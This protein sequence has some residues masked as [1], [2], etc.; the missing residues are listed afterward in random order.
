MDERPRVTSPCYDSDRQ[1]VEDSKTTITIANCLFWE[2]ETAW[3]SSNRLV[4]I[5]PADLTVTNTQ[6]LDNYALVT[7][8]LNFC[9]YGNT[10]DD[11]TGVIGETNLIFENTEVAN[12]RGLDS[13]ERSDKYEMSP[14]CVA[15]YNGHWPT[16]PGTERPDVATHMV[17]NHLSC[18]DYFDWRT[19]CLMT[20]NFGD[21]SAGCTDVAVADSVMRDT[22]GMQKGEPGGSAVFFVWQDNTTIVRTSFENGGMIDADETNV[23]EGGMISLLA[24]TL[25][26][27]EN[28]SITNSKAAFGAAVMFVGPGNFEIVNS[29]FQG[30]VALEQGG[31]VFHKGPGPLDIS[32]SIFRMNQVAREIAIPV[33]IVVH[34][35]TGAT[36]NGTEILPVWKLDGDNPDPT[37]G[38]CG[39]EIVYG[40]EEY[41]VQSTYAKVITT[42]SGSHRLWHGMILN[43]ASAYESWTG[44]GWIDVMGILTRQ[45]VAVC[46]NRVKASCACTDD[47]TGHCTGN[48]LEPRTDGTCYQG[49]NVGYE[50]DM[51]YCPTGQTFWSYTDI[52]VPQGS[53]GAIATTGSAHVTVT[54]SEFSANAAGYGDALSVSGSESFQVKNT[55]FQ[56][57]N[58]D[59]ISTEG[60]AAYDCDR[61]PCEPG[62][63]CSVSQLS[64]SCEACPPGETGSNGVT[65]TPCGLGTEPNA[66]KT[67]CVQCADGRYSSSGICTPCAPGTVSSADRMTCTNC[68]AG[69]AAGLTTACATCAPNMISAGAQLF[70]EECPAGKTTSDFIGCVDC[71]D[72]FVRH[73]GENDC[74]PCSDG[75]EPNEARETCIPCSQ[76]GQF[77]NGRG[78]MACGA[79]TQPFANRTGCVPCPLG[80]AGITGICTPCAAG[81]SASVGSPSCQPCP[82]GTVSGAGQGCVMCE[83]GFQ[84]SESQDSCVSCVVIK[85]TYSSDGVECRDCPARQQPSTDLTS[86]NCMPNTYN[87]PSFGRV[88]CHGASG[89]ALETGMNDE[90]S[91]CPDCLD[92]SV[93]G[94]TRLKPG[95]AFYGLGEAFRCPGKAAVAESACVGP[96]L[97]NLSISEPTWAASESGMFKDEAMNEQCSGAYSGPVCGNCAADFHHLKVGKACSTCNQG[98][99]DI[100]ML[101]GFLFASVVAGGIVITGAYGILVDHGVITDL[102][103]LLGFYQLLGQM[104]NVLSISF[105][106]PVPEMLEMLGFL[107]LDLRK[108]IKMDCWD[109]GAC[110]SSA[111][112]PS[113]RPVF[114]SFSCS[115]LRLICSGVTCSGGFYGKLTTNVFAMPALCVG[116]CILYYLNQRRTIA[117]V[118]AAGGADESAY[119][120][121]TVGFQQ[122][123]F[124]SIF[125]LCAYRAV[126]QQMTLPNVVLDWCVDTCALCLRVAQTR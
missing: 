117:A 41:D 122:N 85:N 119:R 39:D 123:M 45:G 120:T 48:A 30:N 77:S 1:S 110:C 59:T 112:A 68:P 51:V 82:P 63:R 9:W 79:G 15:I 22:Y 72:G 65:C 95:W 108:F 58:S 53:G 4:D 23:G 98:T 73:T 40:G 94:A 24:T 25:G 105:P 99:V 102:R 107:F 69:T 50:G 2:L 100:P 47:S 104:D 26:R 115:S 84:P 28:V 87:A 103:L 13:P 89:N 93:S 46:D 78:C 18:H 61:F 125:L 43:T 109:I 34:V 5:N 19:P 64:L 8:G 91:A 83:P 121:T 37:D 67:E 16:G 33:T 14:L 101:I 70:C 96:M 29:F 31:A 38:S 56:D 76:E 75:T 74:V 36:G 60:V 66:D 106:S 80:T 35:F 97:M 124:F 81:T 49:S 6:F 20:F 32:A 126:A 114:G 7:S 17:V 88:Q 118:I 111:H 62:E 113:T 86:C 92:C 44:G 11:G 3:V 55:Q 42:M 90:C 10:F 54:G 21:C 57:V 116:V 71:P 27:L 12:L 52:E